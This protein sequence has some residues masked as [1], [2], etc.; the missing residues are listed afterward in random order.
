[1][2][3]QKIR[4]ASARTI[5]AKRRCSVMPTTMARTLWKPG[6][7][8]QSFTRPQLTARE[9]RP[10]AVGEADLSPDRRETL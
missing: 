4:R 2:P 7:R 9:C 5:A 8:D 6:V 3:F 1:M 10:F